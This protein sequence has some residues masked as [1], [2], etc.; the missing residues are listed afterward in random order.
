[1]KPRWDE[2]EFNTPH[3][4]MLRAVFLVYLATMT[5]GVLVTL[6]GAASHDFRLLGLGVAA[7]VVSMLS[8]EWLRRQGE[9]VAVEAALNN[10]ARA[11]PSL[12]AARVAELVRLLQEWEQLE[13]KRGSAEFDPWAVQALRHDIR[14]MVEKNPALDRLFRV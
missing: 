7:L 5:G 8:R 14:V 12:D 2:S 3:E 10:V 6:A 9:L 1:M 13:Q 4:M 11:E